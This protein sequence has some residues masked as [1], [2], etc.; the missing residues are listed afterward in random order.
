VDVDRESAFVRAFIVPAKRDRYLQLLANPRRRARILADL[1]H[2]LPVIPERTTKIASRLH[3]PGPVAHLLA[4]KGAGET[5]YLISPERDLDQREMG[6]Q[7]AIETLIMEDCVAIAC[8]IP[9]RLAYYN[10][11]RGGAILERRPDD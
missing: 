9:G 11:E 4:R 8:C 1:Y 10:A 5:C 6:L 2:V 3:F 7:E